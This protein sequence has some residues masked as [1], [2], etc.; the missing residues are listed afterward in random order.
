MFL[1]VTDFVGKFELHTGMYDQAKLIS[2]I[3]RYEKKYLVQLFGVELFNDFIAD[4]GLG[5]VPNSPNFKKVFYP[6][7]E[8]LDMRMIVISEGILDMLKGF[9]Y[10]EY[11]KDLFNQM[12]PFGNVSQKSENSSV[13]TSLNSMMYTRYN[14][15]VKTYRAIQAYMMFNSTEPTG[16]I[17]DFIMDNTGIGYPS[18]LVQTYLTGG[19]G[20]GF[21]MDVQMWLIGGVTNDNPI[22][23]GGSG[24]VNNQEYPLDYGAGFGAS[25]I[26]QT[27][28]SGAVTG[29]TV[30]NSGEGYFIA[31]TLTI[32]GGDNNAKIEL[33]TTGIG[34][35]KEMTNI[36]QGQNYQIDDVVYIEGASDENARITVLYVGIG[37]YGKFKGI[38]L[39][40]AYWL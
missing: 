33:V 36:K 13:V 28:G 10:F 39:Q 14:E 29:Y 20:T 7:N 11:A 23:Q 19:S 38:C 34:S 31:D 2:Y 22:V 8:Q 35:V 30:K 6:F 40:Y 4:L 27:D 1:G 5:I 25:V 37:D 9:I 21:A 12:T 32:H 17:V 24:Y 16:Q 26:V 3:D 18:N 15:S